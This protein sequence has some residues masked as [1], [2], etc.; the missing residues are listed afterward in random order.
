MRLQAAAFLIALAPSIAFADDTPPPANAMKLS[1]V[2]AM[3][4][5]RQGNQ[6]AYID[7]ADWDD[8]GYWE[9]EYK[10]T[11]GASIEVKLD[12]VSGEQRNQ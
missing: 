6:L 3:L 2:I 8:D 10:T 5:Q 12:P 9:V 11:D 7:Q 4:E 1:E